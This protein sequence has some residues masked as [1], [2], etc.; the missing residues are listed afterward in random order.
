MVSSWE[1]WKWL[2]TTM[3]CFP[4]N[5]CRERHFY[6]WRQSF[7]PTLTIIAFP[8]FQ[9][10]F[11][12]VIY[13]QHSSL[14]GKFESFTWS[15]KMADTSHT[16][17]FPLPPWFPHFC[18]IFSHRRWTVGSSLTSPS[19]CVRLQ[20]LIT[21]THS[22]FLFAFPSPLHSFRP[23]SHAPWPTVPGHRLCP[24]WSIRFTVPSW[25]NA[26]PCSPSFPSCQSKSAAPILPSPSGPTL[27]SRFPHSCPSQLGGHPPSPLLPGLCPS[28]TSSNAMV[29]SSTPRRRFAC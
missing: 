17:F 23:S 29:S 6:N 27:A 11:S 22:P 12:F 13:S 20:I 2:S 18:T 28:H 24:S 1:P 14:G 3:T 21:S 4:G 25:D 7:C 5:L 9:F 10:C 8:L 19:A 26:H 15:H 16:T